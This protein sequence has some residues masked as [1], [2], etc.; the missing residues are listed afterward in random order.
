VKIVVDEA[1]DPQHVI[2]PGMSAVPEVRVR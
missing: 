1:P 2:G